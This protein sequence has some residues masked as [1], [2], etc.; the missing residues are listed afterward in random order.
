MNFKFVY[1]I[2]WI[3]LL[4]YSPINITFHNHKIMYNKYI[5]TNNY[6]YKFNFYSIHKINLCITINYEKI[7]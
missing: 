4:K 5:K 6:N 3:Y 2:R 1:Y 7:F